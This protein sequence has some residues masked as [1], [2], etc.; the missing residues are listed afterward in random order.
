MF[1]RACCDIL[2]ARFKAYRKIR[3]YTSVEKV[4]IAKGV[5]RRFI[6]KL[7]KRYPHLLPLH[8]VEG[9]DTSLPQKVESI[10]LT[11][12]E[13]CA[14]RSGNIDFLGAGF[15]CQPISG[16]G[17]GIRDDVFAP[18]FDMTH[19]LYWCRNEE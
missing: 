16:L 13:N 3:M 18:F 9:F 1:A 4:P 5:A 2:L 10:S 7:F 19:I 11:Q 12:L 17:L 8:T 15:P 14:I 6:A